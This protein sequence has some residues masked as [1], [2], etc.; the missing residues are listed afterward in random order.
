MTVASICRFPRRDARVGATC[1]HTYYEES[2]KNGFV[3]LTLRG[4]HEGIEELHVCLGRT[5]C[6]ESMKN[7]FVS[8]IR[9]LLA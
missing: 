1:I 2:M 3:S 8:L 4:C 9:T 5:K 6:E 7:G